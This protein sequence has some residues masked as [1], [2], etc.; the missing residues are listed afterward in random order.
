MINKINNLFIL[1]TDNTS[2][3]FRVTEALLLEHVYYGKKIKPFPMDEAA[4]EKHEFPR[5][6]TISYSDEFNGL[7]LE[8]M[9]LEYS[10]YGKGDIR[11]PFIL[12]EYKDGSNT[13]DFIY[14]EYKIGYEDECKTLPISYGSEKEERLK[15]TLKERSRDV[16]LELFY[17]I[18]AKSNVITR[19]ANVV[20]KSEH[21][22]N[23]N[24][25][26]SAQLDF[27]NNDF[28]FITFSGAWAREMEINKMPCKTGLLVNSSF[29]GTSSSRHNPFVMLS[30]INSNQES[31]NVYGMNLIYSG[32][33][34][35]AVEINSY[36]KLRFVSGINP[37]GFKWGLIKGGTFES[38]EAVLTYSDK[39]FNGISHNMHS[40]V[41]ENIIRGYW[42]NRERPVLNNS[43]E[44]AYFD[45]NQSKILNMAKAAKEV[46]V[47]LF[48][49]DDGWFG[50]R[51]DDTKS[52][53][54]WYP[55]KKKLP[56][57][58]EGIANKINEIGLDFG[59]WVEPEMVN[60]DSDLY[61]KHP[62]YAMENDKVNQSLGRNQ[63]LLDL[64]KKEVKKYI[65]EQMKNLFNS[66]NIKYVKWDM[67]RIFSD[68]YS[69]SLSKDRQGEV[70]HRY[71]LGLYEIL[72]KL[73]KEFT[74]ILFES[75]AS[76]G[77]R[78]D[79]GMLCYM[80]QIWAS[81]NTDALC[82][83]SI[84]RGYSYGYPLSTISAH[85]SDSPNHQTLRKTSVETRFQVACFGLL[86][87]ELNIS[88]LS[89]EEK[90][91]IKEQIN[92]YKEYRKDLQF[93]DFKRIDKNSW[94]VTNKDKTVGIG[95]IFQELAKPNYGYL[96]FISKDLENDSHYCF[97]NR[98]IDT[99]IMEFGSLINTV[100]PIHI[101]NK[102][103]LHNVVSK[104]VKLNGEVENYFLTGEYLNNL[105]V[106][107]KAGFSGTGYND[108]TRILP[109]FSSR[110]F[111]MEK[112]HEYFSPGRVNL[113]GEH[114]DY[115]GGKVLPCAISLGI[116]GYFSKRD[117]EEVHLYSYEFSEDGEYV[118]DIDEIL[119]KVN[120]SWSSYIKA[121][122][123][124]IKAMGHSI[125]KGF[126]LHVKSNLPKGSG[127]SSSASLE[128]LTAHIINEEYGLFIEDKKLALLCQ[129]AENE[130]IGVTCG[131]MD[132]MAVILGKRNNCIYLDTDNLDYEYVPI[133][134]KG[135]SIVICN[136]NKERKLS[137]SKY[138]DRRKECNEILM[139]LNKEV[140]AK[141]LCEIALNELEE[142]KML[143]PDETFYRRARH[144]ISENKRVYEAKELL[145]LND[146]EAFGKLLNVSHDSLRDDY[147][148]TGLELDTIVDAA[149]MQN[150]VLGARMTGAGFSGC[151]I[152]IVNTKYLQEFTEN[153]GRIYLNK[154]GYKASFETIKI[155]DGTKRIN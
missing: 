135:Y 45:F 126:N 46:G 90:D 7:C 23:I 134:L 47:E 30:D 81:D 77:N 110:I 73:Q 82:R 31:G 18:Y 44:A 71:V 130:H 93:G 97:K 88:E 54:D 147:E 4:R 57:G 51:N 10:S 124:E 14:K 13:S 80:P 137:E 27:D 106:K 21:S 150:G 55:N 123:L 48:V 143:I 64:T 61:R 89:K 103:T 3:I 117:D 154:I 129:K 56:N 53:G 152:A 63:L 37:N 60:R 85:V 35:E 131:I 72:N 116:T 95:M 79:L 121:V 86:G 69:K 109:D 125:D 43:W 19:R 105:G 99:N 133:N 142:K 155:V 149:R 114:I 83:V 29:T 104:F 75:C 107:L 66:G 113:I 17:T 100:S 138:N 146:I 74:E 136:T 11:E 40:F 49:L 96:K 120:D 112:A 33:H 140:E 141:S 50:K 101:K 24:R 148:V 65:Y 9:C 41:N 145:V 6:S 144:V 38:P 12:C 22:I 15:I 127:L 139:Y 153:V 59:I 115:N 62:E 42:K 34:Y 39:G 108:D 92:W 5:G 132:Q 25:I 2:Y 52:L 87:Y 58:I 94:M 119:I 118:F 36:D 98:V 28:Q 128:A 102:S 122:L 84:Q 1:N 26:M 16:Y 70:A 151:A 76:G 68:I 78:F 111:V 67:N 32:N 20:N 8:D 91:V